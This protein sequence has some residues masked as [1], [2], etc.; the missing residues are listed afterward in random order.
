MKNNLIELAERELVKGTG[1][2]KYTSAH[3][4]GKYIEFRSAGGDW[5][6]EANAEPGKLENTMMRYA[7]AMYLAGNPGLERKE[8]YKKLY[9]LITP[10]GDDPVMQLFSQYAAGVIDK[11]QLKKQWAEKTLSKEVPEKKS[12]WKLY[13]NSTGK[14]VPGQEYNNFDYED[15]HAR[16]KQAVSPGSSVMDFDRAY[17]LRNVGEGSGL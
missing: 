4:Q 17:T 6:A 2:G 3:K 1:E 15:A 9:K 8:Y 10:E 14:A 12:N 16:A 7:Y 13:D 11:E 5:L